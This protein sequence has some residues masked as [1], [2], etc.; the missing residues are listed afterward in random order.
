VTE[1]RAEALERERQEEKASAKEERRER[2]SRNRWIRKLESDGVTR[3]DFERQRKRSASDADAIWALFNQVTQSY[4]KCGDYQGLSAVYYD[5][6]LF[7]DE[8]GKD[9]LKVGQ[10]AR[11]MTL[12]DF[13]ETGVVD[14][15]EIVGGG[16]CSK[17]Q[18]LVGRRLSIDEALRTM[19]IP[20]AACED[21]LN[22]PNRG[23]CRCIYVAA[24]D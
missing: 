14:A 21:Y 22:Y 12:M 9:S 8:E 17:C 19:P 20:C 23:L 10:A 5:M 7:L 1:A 6:A 15:V 11:K 18:A 2:G 13:K 3:E 16:G 24:V 4:M